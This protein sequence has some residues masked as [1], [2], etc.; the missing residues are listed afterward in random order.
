MLIN[1]IYIHTYVSS[2]RNNYTDIRPVGSVSVE[3][4]LKN[5][6]HFKIPSDN[7]QQTA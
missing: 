7:R 2:W 6:K 5:D 4:A 1:L 3:G